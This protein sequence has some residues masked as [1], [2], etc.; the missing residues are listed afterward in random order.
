MNE[1]QRAKAEPLM[2][3]LLQIKENVS[4]LVLPSRC[5]PWF[6]RSHQNACAQQFLAS[7]F[8]PSFSGVGLLWYRIDMIPGSCKCDLH[9]RAADRIT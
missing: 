8:M 1:E 7:C 6:P 9:H 4:V 5:S 2:Q 3:S